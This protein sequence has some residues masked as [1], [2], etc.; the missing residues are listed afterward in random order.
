VSLLLYNALSALAFTASLKVSAPDR[1]GYILAA[2]FL[3][4]P[5]LYQLNGAQTN[6]IV[7]AAM[8]GTTVL[9]ERNRPGVAGFIMSA[10]AI[11]K[12]F[13]IAVAPM[14]LMYRNRL[15]FAIAS[16]STGIALLALPLLVTSPA[17]LMNQYISWQRIER[18]DYLD[19]GSS[20]MGLLH[21]WFGISASN[22]VVQI[23]GVIVLI[24]PILVRSHMWTDIRFRR[25]L[26]ASTLIF[27][28]LF[29]HQAEYQSYII[30]ATGLVMW[31]TWSGARLFTGIV[32]APAMV[33]LHPFPYLLAWLLL[34]AQLLGLSGSKVSESN[35][36]L[37]EASAY[38]H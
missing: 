35:I 36:A 9:I 32:V 37:P 38:R 6:P 28:V 15:R 1:R 18:V 2:A 11:V 12:I 26:L 10:S 33:A 24:L 14:S 21:D 27:V 5:F 4:W 17:R 16:L 8:V 31:W 23:I 19:R 13:P 20:V 29:N 22:R 30:A 25:R 3:L 34:Q 7:L